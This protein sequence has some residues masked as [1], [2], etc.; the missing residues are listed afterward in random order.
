[1]HSRSLLPIALG[2]AALA[3]APAQA[4]K[5]P[6]IT[7]KYHYKVELTGKQT[8]SWSL[9][10]V[11]TGPCDTNQSGSGSE[12]IRFASRPTRTYTFDG[13]D[14]PYFFVREGAE[15][16]PLTLRPRGTITRRGS[17]TTQPPAPDAPCPDGVPTA[18]PA[19]DCGRRA[20]RGLVVQPEYEYG[21]DRIVLTQS[22]AARDPF[23]H[24]PRGGTTWPYLL[25]R[26]TAGRTI[27]R[28]L[29]PEDLFEHGKN[30][31]IATGV[32]RHTTGDTT[33]TTRIRWELS[34]TRVKKEDL[35]K[36]KR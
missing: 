10:H 25:S 16:R 33:W 9:N 4:A 19:P 1:M 26:D 13:L 27:G 8:T 31:L 29:P 32:D 12:T 14:Q 3:A 11:G 20:I 15:A 22:D 30:I 36:K 7:A 24:C 17:I 28:G 35:T 21:K 2:L 6:R 23:K 5:M 18:P 34:F